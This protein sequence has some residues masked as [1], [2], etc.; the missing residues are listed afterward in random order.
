MRS[1]FSYSCKTFWW[2][3]IQ[4]LLKAECSGSA[5]LPCWYCVGDNVTANLAAKRASAI[6]RYKRSYG[7][8]AVMQWRVRER[9]Q[10][11]RLAAIASAATA[12]LNPGSSNTASA[13]SPVESTGPKAA[14]CGHVSVLTGNCKAT[15]L[16][17]TRYCRQHI[18]SDSSQCLFVPCEQVLSSGQR[19]G[20][21]IPGYTA[22]KRCFL[23]VDLLP[24]RCEEKD[25]DDLHTKWTKLQEDI[26][27]HRSGS[28]SDQGT[29]T[30]TTSSIT[31]TGDIMM[32]GR[33]I[34]TPSSKGS[35]AKSATA[36]VSKATVSASSTVP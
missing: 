8:D 26:Q 20:Q 14:H 7:H 11:A 27:A 5:F 30:T 1:C 22:V 31:S 6:R 19:C 10:K 29:V 28:S 35:V 25:V 24:V 34:A 18:C 33:G 3:F 15:C 21:P 32:E 2:S 4:P 12:A 17:L 9:R 13:S 36:S 23:H 16:P